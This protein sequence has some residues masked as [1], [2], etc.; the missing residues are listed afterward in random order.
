MKRFIIKQLHTFEHYYEVWGENAEDALFNLLNESHEPI[1]E[2]F[3]SMNDKLDWE[4]TE[5]TD[6]PLFYGTEG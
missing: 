5:N 2:E 1:L 4:I 3:Q 6:I